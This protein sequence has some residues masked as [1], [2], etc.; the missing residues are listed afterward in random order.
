[1]STPIRSIMWFR[2]ELRKS[3]NLLFALDKLLGSSLH[4]MA[5]DQMEIL[6]EWM[7][8]G[9]VRVA[10]VEAGGI[11]LVRTRTPYAV[12]PGQAVKPSDSTPYQVNTLFYRAWRADGWQ[13]LADRTEK[14]NTVIPR[15]QDRNFPQW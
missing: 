8:N 5:G 3:E 6:K 15:G 14:I 4:L 2:R 11:P 10:R 1:M 9:A 12:A 13:N 7:Q